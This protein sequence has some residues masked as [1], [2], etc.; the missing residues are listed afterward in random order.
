MSF[1]Q[2]VSRENHLQSYEV[3]KKKYE[4]VYMQ[5]ET[6]VQHSP[7]EEIV[8]R[9][10]ILK[11]NILNT[12]A[13]ERGCNEIHSQFSEYYRVENV[14]ENLASDLLLAHAQIGPSSE[15]DEQLN[16]MINQVMILTDRM[17]KSRCKMD[18][19]IDRFKIV[20][21]EIINENTDS[22]LIEDVSAEE[23][24]KLQVSPRQTLES[25]YFPT[26]KALQSLH[27]YSP[28]KPSSPLI[29]MS[30]LENPWNYSIT[31]VSDSQSSSRLQSPSHFTNTS[32]E[33]GSNFSSSSMSSPSYAHLFF[34]EAAQKAYWEDDQTRARINAQ[35]SSRHNI[36]KSRSDSV[37]D[38][39]THA[40]KIETYD[41]DN[42]SDGYHADDADRV[43]KPI[44]S[45]ARKSDDRNRNRINLRSKSV[46]FF[47][48]EEVEDLIWIHIQSIHVRKAGFLQFC[49]TNPDDSAIQNQLAYINA[50]AIRII[51]RI[52]SEPPHFLQTLVNDPLTLREELKILID[53]LQFIEGIGR[54]NLIPEEDCLAIADLAV[55]MQGFIDWGQVIWKPIKDI[56]DIAQKL[57]SNSP[58]AF[59]STILNLQ[60]NDSIEHAKKI[61]Q[62]IKQDEPI[63]FQSTIVGKV[64]LREILINVILNLQL[65][66]GMDSRINQIRIL[67][68]K[69]EERWTPWMEQINSGTCNQLP[70][71]LTALIMHY[72]GDSEGEGAQW[73]AGMRDKTGEE[74]PRSIFSLIMP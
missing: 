71:T 65:M 11:Q 64:V 5:L 16:R 30:R 15:F 72:L 48:T 42:D 4:D 31:T 61:V 7:I 13:F 35:N 29:D 60:L 49:T 46:E 34:E 67:I 28:D 66:N 58:R 23:A 33:Y 1:V 55:Q 39:P 37:I 19:L 73:I 38:Y 40:P 32:L 17:Q 2:S 62:I 8:K 74:N 21:D 3:I 57:S 22:V 52:K 14:I 70:G 50:H 68:Q 51:N 24:T 41:S 12:D 53:D 6:T 20:L 36:P 69:I 27:F 9:V 25:F 47:G 26:N 45:R 44:L 10:N 54:E 43:E 63:Y 18:D 59:D 56:E